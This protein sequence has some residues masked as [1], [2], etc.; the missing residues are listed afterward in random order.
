LYIPNYLEE[1]MSKSIKNSPH[2][3]NESLVQLAEACDFFPV[4]CSRQT[5]E[6]WLRRGSRGVLLE[7]VTIGSRRYTSKEAIARFLSDQAGAKTENNISYASRS[8]N[9][10]RMTEQEIIEKSRQHGLPE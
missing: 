8:Y 9:G 3:I 6:R 1:N 10:S 2:L 5:L 7:S 4:K